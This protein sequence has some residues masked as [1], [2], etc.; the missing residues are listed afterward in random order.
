MEVESPRAKFMV[1]IE[2]LE[3]GEFLFFYFEV[4]W[5]TLRRLKFELQQMGLRYSSSI[6]CIDMLL[7][8]KCEIQVSNI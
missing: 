2:S 1:V 4:K 6:S 7:I 8:N 5:R 3:R